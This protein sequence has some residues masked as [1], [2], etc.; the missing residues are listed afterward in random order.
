MAEEKIME[1]AE[2]YHE[3]ER[4]EMAKEIFGAASIKKLLKEIEDN[5][6]IR[7]RDDVKE[8]LNDAEEGYEEELNMLKYMFLRTRQ[9]L[10]KIEDNPMYLLVGDYIRFEETYI[11]IA[12]EIMRISSEKN[13][14]VSEALESEKIREEA[15]KVVVR[16]KEDY[17]KLAEADANIL[18]DT[19]NYAMMFAEAEK[20]D[21][22]EKEDLESEKTFFKAVSAAFPKLH[23]SYHREKCSRLYR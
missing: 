7:A 9:S 10:Y 2:K 11:Q 22:E 16:T 6:G 15:L 14:D 13:V 21:E 18:K 12:E 17:E 23:L 8:F 19:V 20:V 1:I 3:L 5:H 4:D